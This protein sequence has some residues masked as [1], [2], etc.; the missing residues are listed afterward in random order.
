MVQQ[1]VPSV[2][3]GWVR[4]HLYRV[5]AGL[6]NW[7][8]ACRILFSIPRWSQTID[9]GRTARKEFCFACTSFTSRFFFLF[10]ITTKN[11]EWGR[12]LEWYG[13]RLE[14]EMHEIVF[15]NTSP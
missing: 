3:A 13:R 10:A 14:S 7:R 2:G 8:T 12:F 1:Y 11:F 9:T 5:G 4:A 15:Q 6:I